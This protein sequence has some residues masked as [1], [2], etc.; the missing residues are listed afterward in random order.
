VES[1]G[2]PG[3]LPV[4][5]IVARLL[6]RELTLENEYLREENRILKSKLPGRLRFTDE[7]RRSLLQSPARPRP[8]SPILRR[9]SPHQGVE[10]QIPE[11]L[12]TGNVIPFRTR[13]ENQKVSVS[14]ESFLGGL[15]NSYYRKAA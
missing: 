13:S 10:N 3:G 5:A 2:Q 1:E 15:L 6:C 11:R 14:R 8:V 4:I 12:A 7:E 9:A